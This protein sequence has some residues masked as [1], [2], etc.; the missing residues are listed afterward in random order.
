MGHR[1]L[2]R[3]QPVAFANPVLPRNRGARQRNIKSGR[4]LLPDSATM[5]DNILAIYREASPAE[6]V[7]GAGWYA[8]A[9]DF[10]RE[11][12]EVNDITYRQACGIIAALSP[13]TSWDRNVELAARF[14][15]TGECE[16]FS[17]AL[18]KAKAIRKGADPA[19]VL[20]GRKVRSFFANIYRPNTSGAITVDRHAVSIALGYNWHPAEK[21]LER[22]GAYTMVASAY[23]TA[24]RILGIA[25][26]QVQA[27]TWLAWRRVKVYD[28]PQHASLYQGRTLVDAE[29]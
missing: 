20:R 11:L 26:Q 3:Y 19:D 8:E 12:S 22:M 25:P 15:A 13:Q 23:R 24:A 7:E 9:S 29:F 4:E 28:L 2:W 21:V 1:T 10:A 5:V 27:I 18:A 16:H 6:L 14:A 17:D